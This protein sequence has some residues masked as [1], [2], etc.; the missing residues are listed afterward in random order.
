MGRLLIYAGIVLVIAGLVVVLGE[1]VGI[2][3]GRLPGDIRVEGRRGS[4]YFPIVTCLLI[5]VILSLI[6]WLFTRRP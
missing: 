6:S 1:R 2:R 3:L 4:F 5:S